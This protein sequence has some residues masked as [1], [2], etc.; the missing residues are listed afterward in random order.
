MAKDIADR[1]KISVRYLEQLLVALKVAG[2]VRSTR[3]TRGGF[4][5]ARDPSAITLLDIVRTMDGSVAPVG[6]VDEPDFYSRV[7]LCAAHDVWT[8]V[9]KAIEKS[10][11][12]VSLKILM[13]KQLEKE[14]AF[15]KLKKHIDMDELVKCGDRQDGCRYR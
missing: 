10:L 15:N 1:Q 6:C 14:A 11:S 4:S 13:D 5:L 2:L 8:D 9:K 7:P 3:G 12:S